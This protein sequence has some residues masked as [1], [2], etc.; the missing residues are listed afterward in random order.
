[1]KIIKKLATSNPC[2][3]AGRTITPKGLMLHSVG[4]PQPSAEVFAVNWNDSAIK[5]CVHAI[6]QSDGTVYQLLPWNY[7]A[8][9]CGSSGNNTHIGVEMT[10][11]SCI[12]YT[13]GSNFT[14]SDLAA[15][16]QQVRGTYKT[17]VELFAYL[18]KLY[19]L[20]PLTQICSHAEG[21]RKGIA[22]NHGDPEHLWKQLG[23]SYT[24]NGFRRDVKAKM[25]GTSTPTESVYTRWQF[26]CDIQREIGVGVDGVPGLVTLGATPTISA[27]QNY[28]H[29]AVRYIQKCLYTIGY[30]E[31]GAADGIAGKKFT[32]A[33]RNFQRDSGCV[34]DGELTAGAKTWR[35]LLGME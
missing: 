6:L 10:E 27:T 26:V 5:V 31:V 35:K 29:G 34:V 11:P 1:M 13:G 16:K 8:W 15:A 20:N 22:S 21:Y 17:A 25:D 14:C 2:Y 28:N 9:H 4:C 3:K 24:M 19:N 33:V 32:Q 18:C 12:R 30:I 23:L 7:R